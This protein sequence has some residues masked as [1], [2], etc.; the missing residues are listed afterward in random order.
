[1]SLKSPE[2]RDCVDTLVLI[3]TLI[4]INKFT[5]INRNTNKKITSV[6]CDDFYRYNFSSLYSSKITDKNIMTE[7]MIE[8]ITLEFKRANRM[9]M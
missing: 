6:Y 2:K 4:T 9:V 8:D 3:F 5:N 7:G 1:M